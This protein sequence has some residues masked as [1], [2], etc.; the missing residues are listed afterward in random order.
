MANSTNWLE[1]LLAGIR[2]VLNRG[3]PLPQEQTLNFLA[4]LVATDNPTDG[5]TEIS[6]SGGVGSG[7]STVDVA[8]TG[9]TTLSGALSSADN[10]TLTNGVTRIGAFQQSD[11]TQNGV[12]IYN[13]SGAWGRATDFDLASQF[14]VPVTIAVLNGATLAGSIWVL[15]SSITTI[16]AD[17][18]VFV[19]QKGTRTPGFSPTLAYASGGASPYE[20]GQ[21]FTPTYTL[22][23]AAN[24]SGVSS[25]KF[26]DNQG[27]SNV[28]ISGGNPYAPGYAYSLSSP[29]TV[30]SKVTMTSNGITAD[31][32]TLSDTVQDRGYYGQSTTNG[33]TGV[34][35]NSSD[36]G[37]VDLVGATGTL[38][39][40]L[41]TY[42]SGH[43]FPTITLSANGY[44][45]YVIRHT[46]T[47]FTNWT[48]RET[49]F[50][51]PMTRLVSAGAYTNQ[52][53]L[54]L[55]VDIYVT[56]NQIASGAKV[57]ATV[58]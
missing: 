10:Y 51:L 25:P 4:P 32:N 36:H 1:G 56:T 39:G 41:G 8:L 53:G 9:N 29:G 42:S 23:P 11:A 49:G 18:I 7:M 14:Q 12:Y 46:T 13:S 27:H 34:S 24:A 37:N 2:N 47:A 40:A 21:S 19:T 48:D 3:A 30:T 5:T 54:A 22:S 57:S 38:T 31:S 20:V 35:T 6:L 52:H 16:G 50:N 43:Q 55:T 33:A 58:G 28:A 44:A 17:A 45:Y 15:Q 26:T